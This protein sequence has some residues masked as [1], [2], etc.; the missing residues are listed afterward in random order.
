MPQRI[1]SDSKRI[2][3]VVISGDGTLFIFFTSLLPFSLLCM[4]CAVREFMMLTV[5]NRGLKPGAL[6]L[7]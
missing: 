6:D 3:N 2:E 1:V 4:P 5:L 7:Q